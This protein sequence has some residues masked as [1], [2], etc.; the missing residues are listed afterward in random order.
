MGGKALN[1]YGVFTER[2]NSDEF[3]KIG[4]SIQETLQYYFLR[5]HRVQLETHVVTCYRTKADHGDLDLLVK[6]TPEMNVNYRQVIDLMF[7]PKAINSNGGVYSFDFQGFQIDFIPI[8]ESKW[9]SAKIYYSY[10]P[11]GNIMGKTY[12]KFGL[13]Y[14]WEG[15]F[16]KYRNAHGTNSENILLT[17]DV[18]R[19]FD[20]GGYDYNRYLK[21]FDTLEE[22]FKFCI[23]SKYFDAEMFQMEN[24]KSIDKKRNRKRGSYH[25]FLNYIKDNGINTKF[26]FDGNKD[27]YIE[28]IDRC[29]PEAML[30]HQLVLLRLKDERAKTI[31]DKFNGEIVMEWLPELKDKKL[32]EAIGKFR[33]DLGEDYDNF[34]LDNDVETI[35]Q[36][37]LNVYYGRG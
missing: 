12:H 15:L 16:Y 7:L 17:N 27:N 32:G 33:Q 31:A 14:G 23:D 11:L 10:D 34:I 28:T 4:E 13:S 36:H 35:R 19:I 21:G 37:F 30:E 29:F 6:I 3:L 5:E 25:L 24:L 20:F 26:I 18:R 9:E 2:K 1:K 8:P 22:I